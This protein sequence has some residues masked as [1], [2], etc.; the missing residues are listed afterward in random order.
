MDRRFSG[1][2]AL[3]YRVRLQPQNL[4]EPDQRYAGANI[5]I[6]VGSVLMHGWS[7][8]EHD[9]VYKPADGEL[10][11]EEY[12]LLDQLNGLVLAG[13]IALEQ[14][15]RAGETRVAS[16]GRQ[17]ANHYEL[18][19]HLLSQVSTANEEP[20][21]ESGL[22]RVDLLFELLTRL[23]FDTPDDL[24]PYLALLHG[25]IE[26]RPLSEQII[27]AL[28][29]E[30]ESHYETYLSVRAQVDLS[31]AKQISRD[32]VAYREMG[33]FLTRWVE[34]ERILRELMPERLKQRPFGVPA[35][36]RV[37]A[38][39][40]S[41]DSEFLYELDQL[42]LMGN[43]LVHGVELPTSSH[44]ANATQ[45]MDALISEIERRRDSQ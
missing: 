10:S 32:E 18:A 30:D 43:Q 27:D 5:E 9:L 8:V 39:E 23:S 37:L 35:M 34:L 19:A 22:G 31:R 44:I 1:Y 3:H 28:I 29:A 13:E 38:S 6:Q 45:R 16:G 41:L 40:L 26:R 36:I 33:R 24:R 25:D 21:M 12:S 42:R 15:Q 17:F 2:S 14:L 20:V 7:E 4:V 11:A